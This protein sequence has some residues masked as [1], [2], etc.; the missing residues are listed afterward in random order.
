MYFSISEND[1]IDRFIE[2]AHAALEEA[3]K[4]EDAK[5]VLRELLERFLAR[6]GAPLM[7]DVIGEQ[8]RSQEIIEQLAEQSF[9]RQQ[10]LPASSVSARQKKR[11]SDT[12]LSNCKHVSPHRQTFLGPAASSSFHSSLPSPSTTPAT[13]ATASPTTTAELKDPHDPETIDEAV[14]RDQ[15]IIQQS[16][17]LHTRPDQLLLL[18]EYIWRLFR[19]LILASLVALVYHYVCT[20]PHQLFLIV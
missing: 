19:L 9:E 5:G 18:S 14:T 11:R 15:F 6:T 17:S 13:L 16:P 4:E 1:D 2:L 3:T 10:Y 7:A 8:L 12:S 20:Y